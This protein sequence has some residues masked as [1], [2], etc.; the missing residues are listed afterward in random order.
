MTAAPF[1]EVSNLSKQYELS[2]DAQLRALEDVSL[3]FD[4]G[5]LTAIVGPSGS[6]KSTLLH[7]LSGIDQPNSGCVLYEGQ[8]LGNLSRAGLAEFRLYNIGVIFQA[9]NLLPVFTARENIEYVL[10]LQ[11][12]PKDVRQKRVAA[13]LSQLGLSAHADRLPN[14]LSGGQQQ[15]T[16]IARAIV[17]RPKVILADEPTANLDSITAQEL[18]NTIRDLNE[19]MGITFIISTH[20]PQVMSMCSRNVALRDGRVIH[21]FR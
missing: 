1:I 17:T 4:E 2:E 13:V 11:H 19:R 21:D 8:E 5:E 10:Q 6:G 9:Y 16:A 20:D 3:T 14:R 15:R 12:V 7:L 18:L